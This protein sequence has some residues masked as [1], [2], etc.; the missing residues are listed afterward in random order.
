MVKINKVYTKK[1]DRGTTTILG[2]KRI[3]KCSIHVSALGVLD[4]LNAFLGWILV[5]LNKELSDFLVERLIT[6]QS[7]LFDIGAYVCHPTS[8]YPSELSN[9]VKTFEHDIDY[10]NV[11]LPALNSFIL[12]GGCEEAMRLHVARTICRRAEID[13]VALLDEQPLI[14][15]TIPFLNR[16]SDWLFVAARYVNKL[17]YQKERLWSP[18]PKTI[19]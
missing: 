5:V 15:N 1:G 19:G 12:P 16:L 18:I 11:Q 4:E 3:S 17:A 9:T 8:S 13:L 6:I 10:M 2:S 14:E 7:Q